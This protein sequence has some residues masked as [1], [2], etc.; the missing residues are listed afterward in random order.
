MPDL[1][2]SLLNQ[3]FNDFEVLL[4]VETSKDGIEAELRRAINGD[5]RFVVINQPCSGSASAGRNH[6]IEVSRGKYLVFVD[7]DDF[8]E[9]DA[10]ERFHTAIDQYGC[11]DLLAGAAKLEWELSAPC[12][13]E[14][15]LSHPIPCGKVMTGAAALKIILPKHFQ[16]ATWRQIYRGDFLR[17]HSDLRQAVGR[18][19]QDEEWTP[20][21]FVAAAGFVALPFVFYHYRKRVNSVTTKANPRS[22]IDCADNLRDFIAFW[23]SDKCPELVRGELASWYCD[24]FFHFFNTKY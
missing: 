16:P 9:F 2:N 22:M 10:L 14:N 20:R 3:T 7:G 6:G 11:L 19:H 17:S 8:L 24:L 1:M 23:N 13:G 18:R 21:V 15:I 5:A 4:V 12:A